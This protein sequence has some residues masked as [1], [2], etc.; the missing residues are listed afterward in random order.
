MPAY[1]T[2]FPN[3]APYEIMYVCQ[4]SQPEVNFTLSCRNLYTLM[5]LL[6]CRCTAAAEAASLHVPTIVHLLCVC[7]H[8]RVRVCLRAHKRT[9]ILRLED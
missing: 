3:Q 4:Y 8:A 7:A 5:K 2:F 6:T 1:R 9:D